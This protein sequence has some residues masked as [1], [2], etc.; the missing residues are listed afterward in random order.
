MEEIYCDGCGGPGI[1]MGILGNLA[2]FRCRN[3]GGQFS[4]DVNE[5]Q[6]ENIEEEEVEEAEEW[7]FVM[8]SDEFDS[9]EFGPY[10]SYMDAV[11]GVFRVLQEAGELNDGVQRTFTQPYLKTS[12]DCDQVTTGG[13]TIERKVAS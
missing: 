9:E 2:W 3:C 5:I 7:A 1:P 13:G 4:C 12:P 10:E 8:S 11:G 6:Q